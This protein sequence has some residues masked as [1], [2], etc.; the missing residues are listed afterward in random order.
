MRTLPLNPYIP[1]LLLVLLASFLRVQA[2]DVLSITQDESSMIRYAREG[3]LT[4]GYPLRWR[5]GEKFFMS[6]YEIVPYPLALA[7][8]VFGFSEWSVRLPALC[9]SMASTGLIYRFAQRLFDRR[10]ALLSGLL[11]AVLPWSVYW[12]SNAFYPAQLQ[13]FTLLTVINVHRLFTEAEVAS[14]CYTRIVVY[15]ILMYLS[16]EVSAILLLVFF[17]IGLLLCNRSQRRV[18]WDKRSWMAGLLIIVLVLLQLTVRTLLR[19]PYEKLGVTLGDISFLHPALTRSDYDPWFYLRVFSTHDTHWLIGF[20]LLLGL[21]FLAKSWN[22]RFLYA[23]GFGGQWI[24]T[25]LLGLYASRYGYFLLPYVLIAAAA[26]TWKVVDAF[27]T[28]GKCPKHCFG[29]WLLP[30]LGLHMMIAMPNGLRLMPVLFNTQEKNFEFQYNQQGAP[31]RNLARALQKRYRPGDIIIV[32]AP[33]PLKVYTGLPGDYFLQSIDYSAVF[34]EPATLPFYADKWVG[35][36]VLRNIEELQDVLYRH[37]RVWFVSAP[38]YA[39]FRRLHDNVRNFIEQRF[40]LVQE[41]V[42]GRLYLWES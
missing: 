30:V 17:A 13:F 28:C 2:L 19:Q 22:L 38:H 33:S 15:F 23:I 40:Q 7:L 1:A 14:A 29:S 36:P 26:V 25:S 12:G 10:T 39:S 5:A 8:A 20:F 18:L 27:T 6:T 4:Q 32:Q 35:N 9:F 31:F 42:N 34:T 3:V 21:G 37:Q 24:L 16:W 11:Y 41:T